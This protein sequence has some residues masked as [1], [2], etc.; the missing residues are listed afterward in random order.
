MRKARDILAARKAMKTSARMAHKA[1][2]RALSQFA[3]INGNRF[4]MIEH[5][6]LISQGCAASHI[7][8][9]EV[10]CLSAQLEVLSKPQS[11]TLSPIVIHKATLR[12]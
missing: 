12:A 3:A 10:V 8:A 6:M 9:S 4:F 11:P 1:K 2:S 7:L 5:A